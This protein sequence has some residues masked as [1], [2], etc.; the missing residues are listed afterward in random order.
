MTSNLWIFSIVLII[1]GL[2]VATVI[3]VISTLRTKIVIEIGTV[4]IFDKETIDD[5]LGKRYKKQNRLLQNLNNPLCVSVEAP[6]NVLL[7]MKKFN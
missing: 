4:E 6:K 5:T 2:F 7:L 1:I 3:I